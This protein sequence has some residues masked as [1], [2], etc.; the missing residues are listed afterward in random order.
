MFYYSQW[1]T[2]LCL[3]VDNDS[4]RFQTVISLTADCITVPQGNQVRADTRTRAS[5]QLRRRHVTVQ[6]DR[7]LLH[8]W[9]PG[10]QPSRTQCHWNEPL[11]DESILVSCHAGHCLMRQHLSGR[12][13]C[14]LFAH[15]LW[16]W[17]SWIKHLLCGRIML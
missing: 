15:L 3:T 8:V 14:G 2:F 10:F 5:I 1:S 11:M 12:M 7:C 16:L 6:S 9:A 4:I 17:A 13:M